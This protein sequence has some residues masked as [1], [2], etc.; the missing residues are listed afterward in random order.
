PR[1]PARPA[2]P[3]NTIEICHLGSGG[4]S[5]GWGDD[6]VLLG[7]YFSRPGSA[8]AA[9]FGR[10]R[11]DDARIAA[12]MRPFA[13]RNVRA[14]MTGHSHFDHLGDI[15]RVALHYAK[16]AA[17]YTNASGMNMLAAYPAIHAHSMAQSVG[18]WVR[19]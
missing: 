3:P 6:V 12:G 14:I 13:Q 8:I 16:N 17:V 19:I 15:P 5:I 1:C 11:F 2:R 9:Q 10:L 18:Q 4:A 7:P